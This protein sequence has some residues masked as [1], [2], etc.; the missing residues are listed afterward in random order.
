MQNSNGFNETSDMIED[1]LYDDVKKYQSMYQDKINNPDELRNE[2]SKLSSIIG[3]K[4]QGLQIE[5]CL[6]LD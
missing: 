6:L 1:I 3:K 5:E 2:M 4:Y